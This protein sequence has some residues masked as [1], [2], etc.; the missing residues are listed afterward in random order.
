M[1]NVTLLLV[2]G[3]FACRVCE[4]SGNSG[5]GGTSPSSQAP[6][7]QSS[8]QSD[9]TT[10]TEQFYTAFYSGDRTMMNGVLANEFTMSVSG[11]SISKSQVLSMIRPVSGANSTISNVQLSSST[12]TSATMTYTETTTSTNPAVRPGVVNYTATYTK[13][14]DGYWRIASMRSNSFTPSGSGNRAPSGSGRTP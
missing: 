3:L 11:T 13:G 5:R 12:A 1:K 9:L 7:G 14:A 2:L 4:F 10:L 8:L 6:T